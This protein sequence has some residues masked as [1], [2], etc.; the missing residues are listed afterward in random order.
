MQINYNNTITFIQN[1]EIESFNSDN[2]VVLNDTSE[3]ELN[4]LLETIYENLGLE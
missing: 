1:A 4:N 3:D 2:V